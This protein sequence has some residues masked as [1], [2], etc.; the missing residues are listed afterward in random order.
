MHARHSKYARQLLGNVRMACC[1]SGQSNMTVRPV[2][3]V[4]RCGGKVACTLT[5]GPDHAAHLGEALFLRTQYVQTGSR[6]GRCAPLT[7][8][9]H[10]CS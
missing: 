7:K 9:G 1:V 4:R 6:R 2:R 8:A 5:P 10:A 3:S